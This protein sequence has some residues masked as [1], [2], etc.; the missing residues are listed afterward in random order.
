M[1]TPEPPVP[2]KRILSIDTL[3]GFD[4]LMISGAGSF[5]F[6]LHGKTGLPWVDALAMQFEHPP[7]NGFTFYDFIF[8][9][10]LFLAG[11]SL[12]FSV[13]K[14]LDQGL[15]KSQIYWK[16][17]KRMMILIALG[18]LDKNAPTPYFDWSQIRFVGV[19]QRIG[20]AGFIVTILYL[21][22]NERKRI[23]WFV[24][25][26]LF[27]YAAMF[28]IPVPGYGAG[29]LSMEGNLHGWIDRHFL[30]GRLLQ[31]TYDENGLFTQIPALC[32]TLLGTL[33]SDILRKETLSDQ[34]KLRYL[35]IA[36][37]SCLGVG[38]LWGLHFPINKHLWSSS[39]I[40]LT[41][42]MALLSFSLFYWVIDILKYRKWTFFFI[43]IGMNSLTI[44][45]A[46]RF[47][48][49]GHTSQLL[50]EGLY[51]WTPEPWHPVFES[52]GALVIVWVFLYVLYRRKIFIK[53]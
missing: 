2:S 50:F 20:F 8:P 31:K 51:S 3:R 27:Y 21:N 33:A 36:G 23:I 35:V 16:A 44:Y 26:L 22:F 47:I 11:M 46:Y 48:D 53:I 7:W 4:M 37:A 9:L 6:L 1:Q 34:H 43:V 12:P 17:F 49:F 42:G 15:S 30:P 10:F 13:N 18:I 52:L 29:N 45:L 38:L 41:G 5:I 24:S 39:F 40:C 14:G 19:L 32:L 28:L 25:L